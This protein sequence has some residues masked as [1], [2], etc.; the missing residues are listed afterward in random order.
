M[1]DTPE[2]QALEI[3]STAQA[4]CSI[5]R[6]ACLQM[7]ED[8]PGEP[9]A[10]ALVLEGLEHDLNQVSQIV[11]DWIETKKAVPIGTA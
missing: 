4:K 10:A 11:A 5:L 8:N 2:H 9:F 3:L 1:Y 7:N 6:L